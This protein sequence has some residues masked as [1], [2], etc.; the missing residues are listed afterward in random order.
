M[1]ALETR[2]MIILLSTDQKVMDIARKLH[3]LF[4]DEIALLLEQITNIDYDLSFFSEKPLKRLTILGH[5]HSG[6]YGGMNADSF[7]EHIANILE[8]NEKAS[9]GFI[10]NLEAIDLIGCELGFVSSTAK[11]FALQVAEQLL[12]KGYQVPIKAF[13][14][15]EQHKDQY[16]HTI[17]NY[18][19]ET[20]FEE[21]SSHSWEFLGFKTQQDTKHFLA[22]QKKTN[23]LF[24]KKDDKRAELYEL[25]EAEHRLKS[26]N[27]VLKEEIAYSHK[28]MQTKL[29]SLKTPKE[30]RAFS[31][32]VTKWKQGVATRKTQI[33]ENVQQIKELVQQQSR[34]SDEIEILEK[35]RLSIEKQKQSYFTVIGRTNNP[36]EYF[37]EHPE[38]NFTQ[39]AQQK[40]RFTELTEALLEQKTTQETE[41]KNVTAQLQGLEEQN[42]KLQKTIN[43]ANSIMEMKQ[44][45]PRTVED[46]MAFTELE[47]EWKEGVEQ[48]QTKILENTVLIHELLQTQ[49]QIS[50]EIG[51][52]D[53]KLEKIA[54]TQPI[55]TVS[56]IQKSNTVRIGRQYKT[57]AAVHREKISP[58][59]QPLHIPL[60][61]NPFRGS[62]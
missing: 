10:A 28:N 44:D 29:N 24:S 19:N 42:S 17:T 11:S 52:I 47:Q 34:I 38:C 55:S 32:V 7:A 9:P 26:K 30:K 25:I 62:S 57:K 46:E 39:L 56:P 12:K 48:R 14:D 6:L 31:K 58:E 53:R 59:Q 61:P 60:K 15:K 22:A 1:E 13:T 5:A 37:A 54:N 20:Y 50:I 23:M 51:K 49:Q 35:E 40:N 18:I 16:H 8:T 45:L 41:L 27:R 3:T 21:K 36:R 33:A 4:Q 43:K 2:F